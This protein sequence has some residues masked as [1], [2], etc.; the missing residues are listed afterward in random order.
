M[1]PLLASFLLIGI[2]SFSA[3]GQSFRELDESPLDIAYYPDNF[4]HDRK[5]GEK[6]LV[7]V[8]YSRPHKKNRDLFGDLVPYGEVWR[9]GANEAAEIKFYEDA[10]VGE[11]KIKAGTYSLFTI[12]AK[13]NWTIILNSDLDY[14]GAYKYNQKNDVVRFTA[15]PEV[16][17][18]E[19]EHFTIQFANE[20]KGT[21]TMMLAWGNT[22]VKVPFQF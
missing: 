19:A 7:K 12:P 6:P 5:T 18:N 11:K 4:A 2:L 20:K 14:W 16:L 3:H 9:T 17:K 15:Q 8:I 10:T 22:L 1:K 13:E 21:G